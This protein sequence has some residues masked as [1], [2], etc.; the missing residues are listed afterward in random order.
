MHKQ[1]L[2]N[3]LKYF[4]T[5]VSNYYRLKPDEINLKLVRTSLTL[6]EDLPAAR[7]AVFEYFSIVFDLSVKNYVRFL[8]KKPFGTP[9]DEDAITDI[10]ETLENLV[11]KS[12]DAWAP[13]ISTWSLRL[14]GR[15]SS[16]HTPRRQ[17]GKI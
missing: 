1:P 11:K 10:Q 4:V 2:I 6:L 7:E 8:D 16:E 9:P 17:F 13:L 15:L 14:L 3:E 12:P 5:T